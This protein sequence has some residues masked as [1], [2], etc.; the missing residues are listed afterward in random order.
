MLAGWELL[1]F[2]NEN[3]PIICLD[4]IV[5]SYFLITNVKNKQSAH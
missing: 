3:L 5:P 1:C 4:Y 2:Q